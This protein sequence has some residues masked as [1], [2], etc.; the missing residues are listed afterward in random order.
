[1]FMYDTY[2]SLFTDG[3]IYRIFSMKSCFL[4]LRW[5]DVDAKVDKKNFFFN[6]LALETD[7][8]I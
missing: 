3:Y 2:M 1:M 4:F 5:F 6:S 8:F 7:Y